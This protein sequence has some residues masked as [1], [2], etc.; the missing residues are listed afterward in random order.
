MKS[1]SLTVFDK[2]GEKL[3]D[4][5]F[6]AVSDQEAKEI[7]KAQLLEKGFAENTHRCVNPQAKLILFH[8]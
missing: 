7:G 1:Y 8:R 5:S 6:T 2:S 4:E 3:L